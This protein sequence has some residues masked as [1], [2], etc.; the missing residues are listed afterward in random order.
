MPKLFVCHTPHPGAADF[1]LVWD[2]ACNGVATNAGVPGVGSKQK[3]AQMRFCLF[4]GL[5]IMDH[6][7]IMQHG[8]IV[9]G[10]ARDE[11]RQRLSLL[12]TCCGDS[13][14]TRTGFI[15][16]PKKWHRRRP[17]HGGDE[18]GIAALLH[19]T[20]RVAHLLKGPPTLHALL[21][22]HICHSHVGVLD[23]ASTFSRI[24]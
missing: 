16:Q 8:E 19:T 21:H 13:L 5:K 18:E 9:I 3:I 20:G 12:F 7:F 1:K 6:K 15:G 11:R 23:F 22:C 17:H 10:L 14:Q 2:A 4:V 24:P